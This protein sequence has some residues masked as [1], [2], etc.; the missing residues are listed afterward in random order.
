M[1]ERKYYRVMLGKGS[2]CSEICLKESFIGGDFGIKIN[3]KDDLPDN[4]RDFNHKFRPIFRNNRPEKTKVAAGLA[5]GALWTISKGIN[6]G[7]I[8][9]CPDGQGNY[10]IGEISSSYFYKAEEVLPHR[11]EVKWY[12]NSILRSSMSQSLKN[13]SGSIGTVC[14]LSKYKEELETLI[15][16]KGPT[17][18]ISTDDS[19]E[20]PN[21][22]VM[23]KHL[24]DFLVKNWPQTELGRYYDIYEEDGELI[25]QQLQTDTGP[26]DI[27]AISKDRKELLVI[28]LKKGRASD[29]VVGQVQRYMGYVL[30]ELAEENQTVKG[31]IIAI[32]EDLKIKRALSVAKNIDFYKYE[33]KFK[34]EKSLKE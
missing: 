5:C 25:G 13:S 3:L 33:I 21:I 4:M 6:L 1:E 18:I 19:I 22:F 23:E 11:R 20:D 15:S 16:G 31:V 27:L 12:P 10:L 2:S 9:L 7:D 30:D 34:L 26:L 29:A 17:T 14:N 32:E 8:V 28:E 24:E